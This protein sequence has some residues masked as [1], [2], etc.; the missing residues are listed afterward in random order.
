ME[1]LN[2]L[3]LYSKL[4]INTDQVLVLI[5]EVHYGYKNSYSRRRGHISRSC[6]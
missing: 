3:L 4:N 5:Q 1:S 2:L 6:M